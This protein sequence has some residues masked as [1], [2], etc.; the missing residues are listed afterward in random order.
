MRNKR[1]IRTLWGIYS[2][3]WSYK[4]RAK[5]D[6]DFDLV[7][8]NEFEQPCTVYVFGKDNLKYLEDMGF[9]CRLVDEKPIVWDPKEGVHQ[10]GHKIQIFHEAMKEFEEIIFLDWDCVPVKPL[11]NDLWQQ[12]RKKEPIQASLRGYKVKRAGWR[13][14]DARKRPCASFVYIREKKIA[15]DM[16]DLWKEK[17]TLSDE[18][19]LGMC[20]D[21]LSGGWRSEETRLNSSHLA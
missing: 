6:S 5:I 14:R 19:I 10:Y 13:K 18:H 2:K 11:S 7:L 9:D 17:K 4:R 8:H 1:F 15:D 21:K 20:M 3:E 16:F 12:L